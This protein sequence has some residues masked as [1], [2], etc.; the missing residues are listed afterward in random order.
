[1]SDFITPVIDILTRVCG[2]C[3]KWADSIRNLGEDLISLRNASNQLND[4]YLDVKM[5]VET[6]EQDPDP[7]LKVSNRVRGWM[8]RVEVLQNEVQ[9]ILQQGEGEIQA[10]CFGG[11]CPKNYRASYKLHKMVA[12]KLS[13]VNDLTS[14]GNFDVIAE[15]LARDGFDE[16]PVDEAVGVESTFEELCSCFGN[17]RVGI[18]GLYG[19]GGVGKTTLL[20]KFNNDFLSKKAKNIVIWVVVSKDTDEGKIQEAIRKKLHVKDDE[21]N[22]KTVDDRVLLLYNILKNEKFVLLLDDVWE[23]IDLLKLGVPS[24]KDHE[25]KIIFTTRLKEVCGLMDAQGLIKVNCLAPDE[26][27]ELFKDKVGGT[28]LESPHI[29]PLAKQVVEECQGLPLA[30]CTVGRAMANKENPN[31]WRRSIEILRHYPS[32]IKGII[33]D[34]YRLLEFSY[35]RLPNDTYKSC[36]LYCALF[37]EDY[38]IKKQKLILLWIAEG[39]LA[40]FDYDIHEARK[41]GEDIISSLKYACLL[42]N[43]EKENTIKMHDVIRDMALWLACDHG[44]K[45]RFITR[46]C[47]KTSDLEVYNHAKWK[48][49]EKLSMW[50]GDE[51]STSFLQIPRCP[52]LITLFV[53]DKGLRVFP[54]EVFVHPSTVRVLNLSSSYK[55]GDLPSEIGD[56]VNLE[57]MNVS[58]TGIRKLPEELKN[59]KKLR[60]LLLDGLKELEFPEKV[61]SGLLSLQAF[62]MRRSQ[63]RGIDENVLLDELEGLDH[64][65]DMRISVFSISSIGKILISSKLQR[66]ICR[67][68]TEGE[69]S[70]LHDFFSSLGKM[71]HLETLEVR[72]SKAVDIPR[73]SFQGHEHRINL[74]KLVLNGCGNIVDLNWLIHAPNLEVL[75]IS[76][77]DSLVE[78]VSADFGTADIE[79]LKSNLFSSLTYLH[80]ESLSN[81]RSICRMALKFPCLKV[82]KVEKC[83]NLKKLPFNSQSA[84]KSLQRFIG[85][86]DQL[87]DQLAW[88]DEAAKHLLSS[89]FESSFFPV[90]SSLDDEPMRKALKVYKLLWR[91]A[92]PPPFIVL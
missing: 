50:G 77:C 40:E 6:A 20:K 23:R 55:I 34:V 84:L 25:C 60:F 82:I 58:F 12:Q 31:E 79:R 11:R 41:Q 56:F 73:S 47:S 36:F 16:L 87:L 59:L 57:H 24:P 45:A 30:L 65:Q 85:Y 7:R 46:D 9:A 91:V 78:V 76:Y 63:V 48:E 43:S 72:N 86:P 2:S 70:P 39:F 21:W 5:K 10:K 17:N 89:K 67:L 38:D 14:K 1:M 61:I 88:E 18:I 83:P 52:N 92:S 26:A 22:N 68:I 29:L 8:G 32:K 13:D 27:F 75:Q 49:V 54:T 37:P 44:K 3:A 4:T 62:S 80:L 81:L 19:M 53:R 15:Q 35:D 64:L 51:V 74:R 71:E 42:E 33:E 66:C 28:I 90:L 69:S